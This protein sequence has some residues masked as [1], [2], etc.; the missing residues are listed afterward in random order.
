MEY[1]IN[2]KKRAQESWVIWR[3]KKGGKTEVG[4][5]RIGEK[6]RMM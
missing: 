2:K 3:E 1:K 4:K 6:K 5:P